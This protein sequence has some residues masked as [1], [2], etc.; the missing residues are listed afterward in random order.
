MAP[1][2]RHLKE[3]LKSAGNY[4]NKENLIS[5]SQNNNQWGGIKDD[6]SIIEQE[7]G[8]ELGPTS[9]SNLEHYNLSKKVY[10][11]LK[12]KKSVSQLITLGGILRKS[13]G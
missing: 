12:E 13:L 6:I 10:N 3:D 9:A 7:L 11:N 1:Y 5:L 4:L 8:I 2:Y